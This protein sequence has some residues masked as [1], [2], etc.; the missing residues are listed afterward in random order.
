MRTSTQAAAAFPDGGHDLSPL[1]FGVPGMTQGAQ[2]YR[3]RD[4]RYRNERKASH[5]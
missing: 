5:A 1:Q 4:D 2:A 3:R